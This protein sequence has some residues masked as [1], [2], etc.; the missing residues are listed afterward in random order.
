M[1]LE[2]RRSDD[3]DRLSLLPVL[4]LRAVDLV[5]GSVA[6]SRDGKVHLLEL[7]IGRLFGGSLVPAEIAAPAASV[8]EFESIVSVVLI[9]A[10][11]NNALAAFF[12][13][14]GDSSYRGTVNSFFRNLNSELPAHPDINAG[15]RSKV[16]LGHGRTSLSSTCGSQAFAPVTLVPSFLSAWH[17]V[18]AMRIF[19][20]ELASLNDFIGVILAIRAV[21]VIFRDAEKLTI[22][23][24]LLRM[25]C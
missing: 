8:D 2:L 17:F 11:K 9:A 6:V 1:L 15:D 10:S 19:V 24:S 4:C 3:T 20:A 23:S 21:P 7:L 14:P 12:T 25:P 5:D 22:K 18:F 16:V 13:A